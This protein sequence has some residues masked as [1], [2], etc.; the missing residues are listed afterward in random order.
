MY[1]FFIRVVWL[2]I[3]AWNF[4]CFYLGHIFKTHKERLWIS[5]PM[6]PIHHGAPHRD[7]PRGKPIWLVTSGLHSI[8]MLRVDSLILSLGF[9]SQDTHPGT[10]RSIGL[11]SAWLTLQPSPANSDFSKNLKE[12]WHDQLIDQ[13]RPL[14]PPVLPSKSCDRAKRNTYRKTWKWPS[15]N[16]QYFIHCDFTIKILN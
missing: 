8:L 2:C 7:G 5:L 3:V 9:H 14:W 16:G 12:D 1:F 13:I 6:L 10:G 11:S 15:N 4:F